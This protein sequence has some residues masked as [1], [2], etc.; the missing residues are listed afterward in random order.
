[1]VSARTQSGASVF[2]SRIRRLP[3]SFAYKEIEHDV[4]ER[5]CY[6][7]QTSDHY[8]YLPEHDVTVSNCEDLACRR[9]AELNIRYGVKAYPAFV[10]R[11]ARKARISTI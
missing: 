7:I 9:A 8:V 4:A 3:S 2:V 5:P 1:M 10:R 11:V 6:D